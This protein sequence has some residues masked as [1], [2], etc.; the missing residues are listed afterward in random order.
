MNLGPTG[1]TTI[2]TGGSGGI[3]RGLVLGFAEEG[4]NVVIATRDGS[5]GQEVADAAADFP[6]EVFVIPTDV[7]NA[8]A[9]DSMVASI[10][11]LNKLV[12][13]QRVQLNAQVAN[14]STT[15]KALDASMDSK[16]KARQIVIEKLAAAHYDFK[17]KATAK[18]WKKLC[19]K[20]K[21]ALASV[22]NSSEGGA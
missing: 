16:L 13:T 2:I 8:E 17:S 3:G 14:Y 6:G 7:T 18:E 20:E 22:R 15:R 4:A 19:K 12:E 1:K 10:E 5:K 11:E 21:E 9:V